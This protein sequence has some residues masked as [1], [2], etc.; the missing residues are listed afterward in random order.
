[1]SR[2]S[3]SLPALWLASTSLS[4]ALKAPATIVLLA[5]R[6]LLQLDEPG[7]AGAGEAH[8]LGELGLAE[9]RAF[10]RALDLDDAAR[11]GHDEIGVGLRLAVLD[12]V[13]VEDWRAAED[14]GRHRGDV[15]GDRR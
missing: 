7:D 3:T 4:P 12:I 14:A 15:V 2:I 1:I 9:R 10:R 11:S 13:E 6:K 8:Q 5:D